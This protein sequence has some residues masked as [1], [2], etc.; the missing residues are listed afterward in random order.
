[1]CGLDIAEFQENNKLSANASYKE[2]PDKFLLTSITCPVKSDNNTN[3]DN[4][5]T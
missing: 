3:N 5:A 4:F 1:L 2:L